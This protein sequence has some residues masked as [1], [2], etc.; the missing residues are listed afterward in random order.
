MWPSHQ[1][2]PKD[3]QELAGR[4]GGRGNA[5]IQQD[6]TG[7]KKDCGAFRPFMPLSTYHTYSLLGTVLGGEQ[8]RT[9]SR[10]TGRSSSP[11][12]GDGN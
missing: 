12:Q 9:V 2:R 3:K 10:L 7:S 5:G 6:L 4:G 1:G 11:T 8:Q